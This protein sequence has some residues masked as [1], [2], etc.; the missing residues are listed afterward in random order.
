MGP[1]AERSMMW[2][3]SMGPSMGSWQRQQV[4]FGPWSSSMRARVACSARVVPMSE[5]YDI[6]VLTHVR[7]GRRRRVVVHRLRAGLVTP[8][9]RSVVGLWVVSGWWG[10]IWVSG[11]DDARCPVRVSRMSGTVRWAVVS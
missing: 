10:D 11:T 8:E 3:A 1:P 5:G 2:P 7:S 6:A 9:A 4:G